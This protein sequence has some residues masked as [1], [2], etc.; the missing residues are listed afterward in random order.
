[1]IPLSILSDLEAKRRALNGTHSCVGAP[2]RPGSGHRQCGPEIW[3]DRA[4][5]DRT[6]REEA[7]NRGKRLAHEDDGA[8][9]GHLARYSGEF[10]GGGVRGEQRGRHNFKNHTDCDGM[11]HGE[12]DHIRPN[13]GFL[14]AERR[15]RVGF[16][17]LLM[18][19]FYDGPERRD[20]Q[21]ERNFYAC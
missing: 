2:C 3:P 14:N 6:P 15:H 18:D 4:Y 11:A 17:L 13:A 12:L 7:G 8:A 5:S 1:M 9:G 16:R 10:L 21:R 20:A 19:K